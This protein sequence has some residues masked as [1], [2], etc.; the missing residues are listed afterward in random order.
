MLLTFQFDI[1]F[2]QKSYDMYTGKILVMLSLHTGHL[3]GW[4][5][6]SAQSAHIAI[7]PQSKTTTSLG[8]VR[9]TT[10]ASSSF[11]GLSTLLPAALL[12]NI[13]WR[14]CSKLLCTFLRSTY[15]FITFHTTYASRP[16]ARVPMSTA[17]TLKTVALDWKYLTSWV[18]DCL[19]RMYVAPDCGGPSITLP[20]SRKTSPI[21]IRLVPTTSISSVSWIPWQ[22][23]A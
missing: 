15:R 19:V 18:L 16:V 21:P 14:I 17:I 13:D 2:L 4:G 6:C 8:L 22:T 9:Q 23:C 12:R 7:W 3:C 5:N 11:K 20:F 1:R 10:Q